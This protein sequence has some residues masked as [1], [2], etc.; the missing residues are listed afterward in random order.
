M[1][2]T[3]AKTLYLVICIVLV[4]ILSNIPSKSAEY[5]IRNTS[6]QYS[7]PALTVPS[8]SD[9]T[10]SYGIVSPH[11]QLSKEI[12]G[13][14]ESF[15]SGACIFDYNNDGWQ[16]I[17]LVNGS[18][19]RHYFGKAEWW[20]TNSAYTLYKN[21]GLNN[22][23]DV[24]ET[25]GLNKF[26]SWGMGC[27]AAD[28]DND[29]DQDLFFSNYGKNLLLSNNGDGT[30]ID[31]SDDSNITGKDWSTSVL[32][33]DFNNDGLIDLY[34]LNYL[35]FDKEL[36]T[37]EASSGYTQEN[38][39]K[40]NQNL[41]DSVANQ[42]YLNKGN[43]V[44]EEQAGNSNLANVTGKSI[45]AVVFD[46]NRDGYQ[47]IFIANG[48]G[49]SNKLYINNKALSFTDSSDSYK[50]SAVQHAT[51]SASYYSNSGE[52]NL[53][54]GS[55]N[56]HSKSLYK[57]VQDT[58]S[59]IAIQSELDSIETS[60]AMTMGAS[61]ADF[62][63]DGISDIFL[64]NGFTKPDSNTSNK[65]QSQIN[66]ILLGSNN[67]FVSCDDQCFHKNKTI[68]KSSRSSITVDIDNDGDTDLLITQNNSL[69]K[70]LINNTK[71]TNW[72]GIKLI[73]IESNRDGL[74][75]VVTLKTGKNTYIKLLDNN[76]FL[77]AH[78]KRVLFNFGTEM[79]ESLS[80]TWPN[81]VS[82][83]IEVLTT[84][85]YLEVTENS[86]A[87]SSYFISEKNNTSKI[88]FP[89]PQQKIEV[90][91]WLAEFKRY[92][93][94]SRELNLLH[95]EAL[96]N[97]E[98]KS[99]IK[100]S[101][102][103]E[104]A[105]ALKISIQALNTKS[106]EVRLK[107]IEYLKNIELEI[108]SRYLLALFQDE[109]EKIKCAVAKTYQHFYKEEEAMIHSKNLAIP[110]LIESL[111]DPSDTVK[112]CAIHA[113]AESETHRAT[114][115]F[116]NLINSLDK[117]N[118]VRAKA[119]SG[120]GK[121]GERKAGVKLI[122]LANDNKE[123]PLNRAIALAALKKLN[124]IKEKSIIK[125]AIS[126]YK[127]SPLELTAFLEVLDYLSNNGDLNI[128]F[129]SNIINQQLS[130][131]K[132]SADYKLNTKTTNLIDKIL[133]PKKSPL[134]ENIVKET[135]KNETLNTTTIKKLQTQLSNKS[136][137]LETRRKILNDERLH[138]LSSIRKILKTIST[139]KEDS[140]KDSALVL[141]IETSNKAEV[142]QYKLLLSDK[143]HPL[144]QRFLIAK[145]LYR[146]HPGFVFKNIIK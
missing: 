87:T 137:T 98:S 82:E 143:T 138:K 36:K 122:K 20:Q 135:S 86:N 52:I 71:N 9:E 69:A 41:Y 15:G 81:G 125:D 6:I 61:V 140:L 130:L 55:N 79:P 33:A 59:D 65:S 40:F 91:G 1:Q 54:V 35:R 112:T 101:G 47:D 105:L 42:L 66:T 110:L 30:F 60:G 116:I 89:R 134:I 106:I 22:F 18:G 16:D 118:P 123:S 124:L 10:I 146:S 23:I 85:Q 133:N 11:R 29:G 2:K 64:A 84:N 7:K 26:D 126:K 28:L 68:E 8:F 57:I 103:F 142:E 99:L 109:N 14:T 5:S 12:T 114:E 34:V 107:A 108:S 73:G 117:D 95:L 100:L 128:I 111:S 37:Y 78:D 39:P 113:L 17:L 141:L 38:N 62:N 136:E 127:N 104:P 48:Q 24:T 43:L 115:P 75:A 27:S 50:A 31:S 70:L 76:S 144:D 88:I 32:T 49:T 58:F 92:A 53:F 19:Q 119:I 63:N 120:L 145:G 72:I 83:S 51:G 67:K 56:M 94:T 3:L 102:K 132:S 129:N 139:D 13:L 97:E 4:I 46:I 96:S 77:S 44:F 93:E 25:A 21:T 45:A 131:L 74:G 121:I 90:L 80:I